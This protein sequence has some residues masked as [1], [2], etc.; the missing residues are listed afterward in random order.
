MNAPWTPAM[1][2]ELRYLVQREHTRQLREDAACKGKPGF[3]TSQHARNCT[4]KRTIHGRVAV[5]RC[6]FCHKWHVGG[7]LEPK[8]RQGKPHAEEEEAFV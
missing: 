1:E 4:P 6:Q 7:H 5:Y 3:D 8:S 2:A